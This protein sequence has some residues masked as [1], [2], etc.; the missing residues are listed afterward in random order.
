MSQRIYISSNEFR[1]ETRE[2]DDD[3]WDQGDTYTSRTF[4]GAYLTS[5]LSDDVQYPDPNL[6]YEQ[7][8]SA[9]IP[10]EPE[11]ELVAGDVIHVVIAEYSSGSTFGHDENGYVEVLA[12]TVD[13]EKAL[14]FAEVART[15]E[16]YLPWNGYFDHLNQIEVHSFILKD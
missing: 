12:A 9:F 10:D 6:Y 1:E 3:G 15:A 11:K 5:K 7:L 16:G 4:T 8:Q 14:K 13:A 2:P